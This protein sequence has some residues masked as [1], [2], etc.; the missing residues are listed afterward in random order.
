VDHFSKSIDAG[1]KA[2]KLGVAT[3]CILS[4]IKIISGIIGNSYA[5]IADG[6]ESSIDVLLSIV[7]WR[8][9]RVSAKEAN[10]KYHFGYGKAESLSAVI[11]SF[12][13]ILASLLITFFSIKEILT[14]HHLPE[15]FT[16]II[17]VLV[18]VTKE[19]LAR[20]VA[21]VG[22][23]V[24]SLSVK[25][26]ATHH[27]ADAL[28]SAA[29]F[30]GILIAL[31]GGPGWESAD[32]YAALFCAVIIFINGLVIL[33][34]A[35]RELMDRAPSEQML[36]DIKKAALSVPEAQF[37]EKIFARKAGIAYFVALHVHADPLMTL[38]D[39]HIVSGKVKTAVKKAIPSVKD[40]L[41]HMEPTDHN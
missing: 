19:L 14:P 8:G 36:E 6:I 11:V 2:A 3:N 13:I 12:V 34:Q 22:D 37:V 26:D 4:I 38:H 16:L 32:D 18:V 35:I 39:A 30:L 28:T 21:K 25:G 10:Q 5:L 20:K 31:I 7:V 40:V 23:S 33:K 9:L 29:A 41:V 27:R 17:L 1:V 24:D 15:P